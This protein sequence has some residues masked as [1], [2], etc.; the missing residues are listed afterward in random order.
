MK[1]GTKILIGIVA[2]LVLAA[3]WLIS[4]YNSMVTLDETV[5]ESWANVETQY[6][7]RFDLIPNLVSTVQGSADFEQE[8]LT[9][10]TEA[11]SA[12]AN[13]QSSG[14][15]DGQIE[16]ANSFDG[17][18]SRLLV[19]VEAYPDIKSTEAFLQLNDQLEG[20]ENRIQFART[21]YNSQVKTYNTSIRMFPRS[22]IAM[23]FGFDKYTSFEGSEG[24][25][26]AVEVKFD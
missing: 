6:Q 13:A 19:T 2:V 8:T 22:I 21:E 24:S 3:G 12:W 7:R 1:S 16:A 20:T 25:E 17:A 23:I 11:R 15:I 10:V 14:D 18:L 5:K 26:D 4:G 9:G